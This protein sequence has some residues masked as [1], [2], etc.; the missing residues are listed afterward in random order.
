[1]YVNAN[2]VPAND[3]QIGE[4]VTLSSVE[5]RFI[6]AVRRT[7]RSGLYNPQ[8]VDGD[9]FVHIILTSVYTPTVDPGLAHAL[10]DPVGMIC[11]TSGYHW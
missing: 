9:I 1:M 4:R 7:I 11:H 5:H 10:F 8:T 6:T 3:I 2:V